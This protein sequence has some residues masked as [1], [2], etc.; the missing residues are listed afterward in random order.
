MSQVRPRLGSVLVDVVVAFL[1]FAPA[2]FAWQS[3]ATGESQVAGL[4]V[5]YGD[6]RKVYGLVPFGEDRITGIE[7]LERSGLRLVTVGFGGM[8]QGVCMIEETG[9]DLSACRAR[10]CQTGD[11]DSPFWQ[12]VYARDG[13]WQPSALGASSREVNG[14]DVDGWFWTGEPPRFGPETLAS[15]ADR[16][17]VELDTLA[18]PV[19]VAAGD[20]AETGA[21]VD[22]DIVTGL[23][24]IAGVAAIGGLLILRSRRHQ[25]PAR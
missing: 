8:G 11:P 9:C 23:A 10:L 3:P 16:A 4:I 6:G 18:A 2:G 13:Q 20:G 19:L 14:G 24:A 17:D 22:A 12:Y 25:Q 7:L 15:I 1:A 5:D 21:G